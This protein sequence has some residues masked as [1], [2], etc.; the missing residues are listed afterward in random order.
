[1]TPR[2]GAA[3]HRIPMLIVQAT[4]NA[5]H[6]T[7]D[8]GS[9]ARVGRSLDA[10]SG[11]T[12]C[13]EALEAR[14]RFPRCSTSVFTMTR[15]FHCASPANSSAQSVPFV[16]DSADFGANRARRAGW[17]VPNTSG[18]SLGAAPVRIESNFSNWVRGALSGK[19]GFVQPVAVNETAARPVVKKVNMIRRAL[20]EL[21]QVIVPITPE[22]PPPHPRFET[23]ALSNRQYTRPPRSRRP[24]VV[25]RPARAPAPRA[26]SAYP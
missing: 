5:A 23:S 21:M 17:G 15:A 18:S 8:R 24:W 13:K 14:W 4:A 9:G 10:R 20:A 6:T 19:S 22:A 7:K 16:Q 12:L 26:R 25:P 11:E 2:A 1:M 3:V